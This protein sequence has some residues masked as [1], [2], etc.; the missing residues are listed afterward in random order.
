MLLPG[1]PVVTF[2]TD[3]MSGRCTQV[4]YAPR[5]MTTAMLVLNVGVGMRGVIALRDDDGAVCMLVLV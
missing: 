5:R 1:V 4:S 2:P 3:L